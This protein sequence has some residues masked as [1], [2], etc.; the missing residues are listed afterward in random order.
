MNRAEA[1]QVAAAIT[2]IRPDWVKSSL[3]TIL[4]RHQHR[5]A[6]DVM[7]AL[8]W[9]AYD[10]D[11][12][13][14][15]RIDLDGPWWAVTRTAGLPPIEARCADHGETLPCLDCQRASRAERH[16]LRPWREIAKEANADA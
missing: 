3:V 9:V 7:L 6:R 2:T 10:P 1:E 5:I 8:V 16:P 14:P 15:A 12:K 4:G 11:T 13:T